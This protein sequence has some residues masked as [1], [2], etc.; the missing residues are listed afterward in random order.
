M[1]Q[2]D[3]VYDTIKG[4]LGDNADEKINSVLNSLSSGSN[5]SN[6]SKGDMND[7]DSALSAPQLN[8]QNI[9]YLMKLR[10]VVDELGT[11]GDDNRSRLLMSLKPYMNGS[12]QKSIDSA[13]K[14][15][16]L[17]KLSALFRSE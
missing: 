11:V 15:L 13:I 10:N 17:T 12:R 5:S 4:L 14:L 6:D 2:Q 7:E 8:L 16:N 1:A 9:D 3:S